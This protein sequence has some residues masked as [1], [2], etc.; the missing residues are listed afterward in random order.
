MLKSL[1]L[2]GALASV[3]A[4]SA[5]AAPAAEAAKMFGAREQVSTVDLS[6]DGNRVVYVAAV[7]D[8][9]AGA[10]VVD[11]SEGKPKLVTAAPGDPEALDSCAF[12]GNT[13]LIC[14]VEGVADVEGVLVPWSRLMTLPADGSSPPKL[15]G[16]RQ[17]FHDARMRQYDGH[18]LDWL[19][20]DD[21]AVLMSRDYVPEV[22]KSDSHIKRTDDGLGVDRVDL[23][24]LKTKRVETPRKHAAMY[25]SDRRGN[26][27]IMRSDETRGELK[28]LTGKNVFYYR[29]A[30]SSDWLKFSEDLDGEGL[31]PIA[32]DAESDSAYALRKRDGRYALHR[33]KLDGSLATELVF[34][35]D[36]VDVD[37]VVRIGRS[38]RVI[39][40]TYAEERREFVYFDPEYKKLQAALSKAIPQFPIVQ[41][42]GASDDGRKLLIFAGSDSDPGRYYV[43]DKSTRQ[44]AELMPVRPE[45]Q[46]Q[47]LAAVKPVIYPSGGV[48]IPGYL[49]LPPGKAAKGLPAVVLP[50][51]GPSS[52]DE[53]GF[54]WLAQFLANQG[55]AVLQPNYRGSSGYGDPW[56][57]ENGFKG[58]RTS[59]GDVAAGAKWMADQGIADPARIS[60]VG[61][62]YGGYAALQAAATEPNLFKAVV[63]I[64]PVTDLALLKKQA[65]QYTNATLVADFVGSGPHVKEG[66]PAENAARIAGPVLM[67]HG[68][69]DLNVNIEQARVMDKAL[70]AA[71]KKSEL[72]VYPKLEHS[73]EDSRARTDMLTRIAAFLAA[74]GGN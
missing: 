70:R 68:T 17:S 39:G 10:F 65:A 44:M 4:S 36:R 58:W 11:L 56:L 32:V 37:D 64:A 52:R 13:Q 3:A 30:G 24:T 27:R 1:L 42:A 35:H 20:G 6:P 7:R 45:L 71:G 74:N 72:I 38:G 55:Y 50:H 31:Y 25:I 67:F 19:P 46:G 22:G 8:A 23:R 5:A 69:K 26:I 51:G 28:M 48:S 54:D 9:A 60:I 40:V 61:W 62:S 34:A 53:W 18:I 47:T 59:I 14:R 43:F 15:L 73:L 66:S 63:A 49:T 41:F 21:G 16:Q 12:G 29:K 2:A 57:N 33:V